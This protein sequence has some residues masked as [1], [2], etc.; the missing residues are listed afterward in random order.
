LVEPSLLLGDVVDR[1]V[2]ALM[3]PLPG[4]E[5]KA[6]VGDWQCLKSMVQS[7]EGQCGQLDQ[8]GMKLTRMFANLC[9]AGVQPQQLTHSLATGPCSG[10]P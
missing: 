2:E 4:K 8:Y 5:G 10:M 3:R 6:V 9:N 1:Y 7:W